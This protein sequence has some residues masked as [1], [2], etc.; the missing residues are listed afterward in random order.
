MQYGVGASW[1]RLSEW[2]ETK[3]WHLPGSAI[4]SNLPSSA[5]IRRRVLAIQSASEE[6]RRIAAIRLRQR[7]EDLDIDDV[8]DSLMGEAETLAMYMAA[9]ALGGGTIG[10][11]GGSFAGGMGAGPGFVSGATLGLRTAGAA[12][13]VFGLAELAGDLAE[14]L[15]RI[16]GLY[17][18]ASWQAYNSVTENRDPLGRHYA[19][20]LTGN[21]SLKFGLAHEEAVMLLLSAV[22]AYLLR[23]RGNL[24]GLASKLQTTQ[25]GKRIAQWVAKHQEAL[26]AHPAL[27]PR[28]P[29]FAMAEAPHTQVTPLR[30]APGAQP[31]DKHA[32]HGRQYR[33]AP[34]HQVPCFKAYRLPKKKI[35]EFD[36]QLKGQEGG[37]NDLTVQEYLDGRALFG[38]GNVQ[39]N[40]R[41]AMDARTKYAK[42][43]YMAISDELAQQGVSWDQADRMAQKMTDEKMRN[44]AALHN[45]DMI[46][47][48]MDRI[49]G[50]G[51][52]QVN[53]TI[54]P[55][56]RSRL[57]ELD[58]IA[59]EVPSNLRQQT[60]LNAVLVRCM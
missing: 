2:L 47:G 19:T 17:A 55:Q 45:P 44:L 57:G 35:P 39:R 48:G 51:D 26:L 53:A 31:N 7:L 37:L 24:N 13:G 42:G 15:P 27:Q 32:P 9:A 59:N 10:A 28:R 34:R 46:A 6:G 8:L 11:I 49:A 23:E 14:K 21:G 60:K 30:H 56:W 4:R 33:R 40:R 25:R 50:F 43:L 41:A 1:L 3:G 16:A 52:R 22:V 58:K 38:A 18:Q 12:I 20:R 36:R 54:G 5:L 29:L